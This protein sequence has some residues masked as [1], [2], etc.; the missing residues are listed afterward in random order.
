MKRIAFRRPVFG[1]SVRWLVIV[2]T[3]LF[4]V[5]SPLFPW[6]IPTQ[7]AA[8]DGTLQLDPT[9]IETNTPIGTTLKP[10]VMTLNWIDQADISATFNSGGQKNTFTFVANGNVGV[11]TFPGDA[12][13][14]TTCGNN[15]ISILNAIPYGQQA[16][17]T[18][19]GGT[20]SLS[21]QPAGSVGS[22]QCDTLTM[23]T[24]SIGDTQNASIIYTYSGNSIVSVG[25]FGNGGTYTFTQSSTPNIYVRSSGG[26]AACEDRIVV[27]S[28]GNTG[29]L[30]EIGGTVTP[31]SNIST[32]NQK[33]IGIYGLNPPNG[34]GTSGQNDDVNN[35]FNYVSGQGYA[36]KIGG[37]APST[38]SG[39]T[40]GGTD[41]GTGD[42]TPQCTA[43]ISGITTLIN[44][45]LCPVIQHLWDTLNRIDGWITQ[46]MNVDVSGIF[47][48]GS[49]SS[50]DTTAPASSCTANAYYSA[51][52]SFRILA[53][54][55]LIIA[56][57]IMVVSEA[58]G[59][60]ILD[61]YTIRKVLPR[62]VVATIGMSLSWPL[63]R[64]FVS[65]FDT[66][67]LDVQGL[68]YAPFAHLG[69]GIS[70]ATT[71]FAALFAGGALL[72]LGFTSLT[73]LLGGLLI[74]LTTFL[75]LIARQIVITVLI[76]LAPIAIAC[77]VLPGTHRVWKLWF[78]TFFGLMAVFPVYEMLVAAGHIAA[79]LT[80][81]GS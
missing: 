75:V 76:I 51:W 46:Q 65:F 48:T 37:T 47:D 63:M 71:T 9:D 26:D 24:A 68:M 10:G 21:Y 55:I 61:A 34:C 15:G 66:L 50:C 30:W 54:A 38:N 44:F 29:T 64:L 3:I 27:N 43:D 11:S 2:L 59:L 31:P 72:L 17:A 57:L 23:N 20:I 45:V 77:Y 52:N 40:G 58:L 73:F 49:G 6:L 35:E 42:T 74:M 33:T 16:G 53:T 60:Q 14:A 13:D 25:T 78:D 69:G 32:A 70:P 22:N 7:H 81:I 56:G 5:A 18:A 36:I 4:A 39:G 1:A 19:Q 62:L 41:G 28:D 79:A 8:A 80:L 67:G 12:Y